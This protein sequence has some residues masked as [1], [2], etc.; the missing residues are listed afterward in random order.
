MVPVLFSYGLPTD[1][2]TNRY[3]LRIK[4]SDFYSRGAWYEFRPGYWLFRISGGVPTVPNFGRGTD[5]S[6]FRSR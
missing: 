1:K 2:L 6:Q 4:D 3:G 5:C